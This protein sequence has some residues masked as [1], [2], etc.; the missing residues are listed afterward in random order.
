MINYRGSIGAGQDS[1]LFLPGKVGVA[2]VND[3]MLTTDV[4]TTKYN[5]D[6]ENCALFGGSH[7]GFLATHISGQFADRFKAVV[8]RNPVIDIASQM[9]STDIPDWFVLKTRLQYFYYK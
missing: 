1:V 9:N 3:C 2:D 8:T 6:G 5:V 7:G 4:A